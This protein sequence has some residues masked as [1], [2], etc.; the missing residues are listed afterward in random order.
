MTATGAMTTLAPHCPRPRP[1]TALAN[2]P[3]PRYRHTTT[4]A[5]PRGEHF[6]LYSAPP[7]QAQT[8]APSGDCTRPRDPRAIARL[9]PS[10]PPDGRARLLVLL[11]VTSHTRVPSST[12]LVP[13]GEGCRSPLHVPPPSCE[14]RLAHTRRASARRHF[15]VALRH[16]AKAATNMEYLGV[17]L[18]RSRSY[19]RRVAPI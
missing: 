10:Q 14:Y 15:A 17:A 16:S 5:V 7:S 2:S 8:L 12:R 19:Y 11:C 4:C 1:P 3:A 9:G 18:L 13:V 6:T